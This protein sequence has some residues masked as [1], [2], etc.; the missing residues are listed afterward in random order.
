MG[1]TR[2]PT[3]TTSRARSAT[4][5]ALT[6]QTR[7]STTHVL[8][9]V[10]AKSRKSP[11]FKRHTP[12]SS[13]SASSRVKSKRTRKGGGERDILT[14][15]QKIPN[16]NVSLKGISLFPTPSQTKKNENQNENERRKKEGMFSLSLSR[17]VCVCVYARVHV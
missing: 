3:T 15:P 2:L 14:P 11:V 4:R 16:C 9:S 17:S 13:L 1:H 5:T 8:G 6:S 10:L 7:R 12:T